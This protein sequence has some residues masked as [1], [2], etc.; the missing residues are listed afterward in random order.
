MDNFMDRLTEKIN[1]QNNSVTQSYREQDAYPD[2]NRGGYRDAYREE[3]APRPSS[4]P[5]RDRE[6]APVREAVRDPYLDRDPYEMDFT[7]SPARRDRDTG[8][9][10]EDI[11]KIG[12]LIRENQSTQSA[13][14]GETRELIR[15]SSDKILGA[16]ST[17]SGKLDEKQPAAEAVAAPEQDTDALI[18]QTAEEI[19]SST[20]ADITEVIGDTIHK[21]DVKLYRN[22]QAVIQE[23]SG[24]TMER[25]QILDL[26]QGMDRLQKLDQL[27]M[28]SNVVTRKTAGLKGMVIAALALSGVNFIGIVT[29]ILKL[30]FE[31]F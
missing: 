6:P 17:L 29:L 16:I 11:E 25:L 22:I 19:S 20:K 7:R 2:Q 26:L 3:R 9:G 21:E 28:V 1:Q 30:V 14:I 31:L 8:A 5:Y 24:R 15:N 27:D 13:E 4:Y 18:K 23:E 10:R 12:M